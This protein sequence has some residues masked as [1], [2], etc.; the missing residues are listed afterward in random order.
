[1]RMTLLLTTLILT[2]ACAARGQGFDAQA[3]LYHVCY[4][5]TGTNPVEEAKSLWETDQ[6]TY[7]PNAD[8]NLWPGGFP[9]TTP[10]WDGPG[11]KP[12]MDT[13]KANWAASAAWR[14]DWEASKRADYEHW[15]PRE[16]TLIKLMVQEIN[17]LRVQAGLAPRTAAQVKA[18]L[19]T[20]NSE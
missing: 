8:T 12:D 16:R 3:A 19:K 1:M 4:E 10:R 17:V 7:D 2:L 5:R 6:T 15:S 11:A 18:A 13:L 20:I 9:I 14:A